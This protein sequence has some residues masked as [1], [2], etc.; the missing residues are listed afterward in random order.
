M[1]LKMAENSLFAILLRK[2][3]WISIVLA[4]VLGLAF[5]ALL[6]AHLVAF[7]TAAGGPFLV[8]GA[9]AFFRQLGTPSE[10]RIAATR[11]AVRAMSLRDFS[12]AVEAA[13][14]REGYTVT[15]HTGPAADF[16]IT[17][18]GRTAMVC[19]KRWKAA[20]IG[21]EPLRELHAAAGACTVQ[22]AVFIG[23]G[24]LS[25]NA[26]RFAQEQKIH[27]IQEAGLARLLQGM[28]VV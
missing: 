15:R 28:V 2:P 27:V 1:K 13:Y 19:C 6:P 12:S 8:I 18:D 16:T 4:V 5:S 20:S 9:I 26:R 11:D 17:R 7:G 25:E 10:A 24:Q 22:E 3:W 21:I 14:Q 23:I